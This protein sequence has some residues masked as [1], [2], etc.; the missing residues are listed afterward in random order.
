M[1]LRGHDGRAL[2]APQQRATAHGRARHE[3]LLR[4]HHGRGAQSVVL[5]TLPVTL[6]AEHQREHFYVNAMFKDS[7][8]SAVT[9]T[10]CTRFE[11]EC[12]MAKQQLVVDRVRISYRCKVARL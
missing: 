2:T 3:Q 6:E 9:P 8:H 11:A 7:T 5:P 10:D 1:L 4:E 12:A